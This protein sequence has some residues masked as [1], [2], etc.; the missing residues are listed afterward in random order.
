M[1]LP[2]IK[3][4]PEAFAL[5]IGMGIVGFF[6]HGRIIGFVLIVMGSYNFYAQYHNNKFTEQKS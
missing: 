5:I 4:F 1:R 2:E 6:I 3:T